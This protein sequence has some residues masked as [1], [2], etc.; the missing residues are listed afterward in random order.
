MDILDDSNCGETVAV[1][2]AYFVRGGRPTMAAKH[3][4][5]TTSL[6]WREAEAIVR[7]AAKEDDES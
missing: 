2:C 5:K 7:E 1:T 3:L 4:Y 6:T